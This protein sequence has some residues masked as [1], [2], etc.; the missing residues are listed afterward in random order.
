M[1]GGKKLEKETSKE[2]RVMQ[3][4]SGYGLLSYGK[5]ARYR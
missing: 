3:L 5:I 1:M 2:H 4:G